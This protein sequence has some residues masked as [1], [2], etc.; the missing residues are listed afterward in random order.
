MASL[1]PIK[2]NYSPP[3]KLILDFV[4][5]QAGIADS[6][7]IK[8]VLKDKFTFLF[9]LMGQQAN[10][11]RQLGDCFFYSHKSINRKVHIV[12]DPHN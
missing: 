11:D 4:L 8:T 6:C 1:D 9:Q 7:R 5:F 2:V 10:K 12:D 3:R